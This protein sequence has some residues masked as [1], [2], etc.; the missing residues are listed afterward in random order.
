MYKIGVASCAHEEVIPGLSSGLGSAILT[1]NCTRF[2]LAG[3][4]GDHCCEEPDAAIGSLRADDVEYSTGG[5]SPH[6]SSM[7]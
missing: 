5:L 2:F 4:I 7:W 1:C 3:Q 6:R